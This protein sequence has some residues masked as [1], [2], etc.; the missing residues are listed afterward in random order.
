[1]FFRK[2]RA[3]GDPVSSRPIDES[4]AFP[5]QTKKLRRIIHWKSMSSEEQPCLVYEII[6]ECAASKARV[7]KMK[8]KHGEVDTPVFMPVGTQVR[9]LNF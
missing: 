6:A 2:Q 9:I 7:G 8:L 3:R 5:K 1:M 4:R